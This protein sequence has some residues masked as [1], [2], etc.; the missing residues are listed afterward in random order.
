M[1]PKPERVIVKSENIP[2]ELIDKPRWVC[3]KWVWREGKNG[4]PGKWTKP[5]FDPKTGEKADSTDPSTW[6]PFD[7]A[8]AEY[9]TNGYD[10]IGFV[11][12]KEY[13]GIDFDKLRSPDGTILEPALTEIVKI[14]SYT[15]IS[16]SY[17]GFKTLTK[18][19]L[20]KG[21]H[22][23]K[24]IGVFDNSRYFCITGDVIDG[25]SKNIE[26]R[27]QEVDTLIRR[28]WPQ[29]FE[30]KQKNLI[31]NSDVSDEGLIA[32]IRKSGQRIKFESLWRGDIGKYSSQSEADLALCTILAFWTGKDASRMDRLFRQSGLFRDKWIKHGYNERTIRKAISLT[33]ETYL[34]SPTG[35]RGNTTEDFRMW[36]H[37]CYGTFNIEQIYRDLGITNLKEKNLIR[38]N[39][40]REVERGTIERGQTTGTYRMVDQEADRIEIL[41]KAPVPLSISIP[42]DVNK[43]VNIYPGN[44][45]IIAGSPNAGKTA[46]DLNF[47]YDNRNNFEVI[48]WSSEMESEELTARTLTFKH[49]R[50]EWNKIVFLKRTHDF[51]QVINPNAVNIIDYL[52]V[53]EGEFFKV[54]DNIRKIFEK[55]DR[56]IALVSIQMD[57]GKQLGWGGPKTLDKARLYIT[58][59]K[60]KMT[61][62]KAKNQT[63]SKRN[64]NV[65]G[66]VRRFSFEN[67][68][69]KFVWEEW[70]RAW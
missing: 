44:I 41:E 66:M 25:V 47:A 58:L 43:L 24:Q 42:G 62:V 32:K 5:P 60:G 35:Q 52:E 34:S 27:Q 14:N 50:D 69:S 1:E 57:P 28:F 33:A 31:N 4:K 68:G 67:D 38:V 23:D 29:D 61:I 18:A 45:L 22:H 63:N 9:K 37:E 55:L 3:W 40:S 15:E 8:Y 7:R 10:G 59:D 65:D 70:E 49:P 6:A 20:P 11:L 13:T 2:Q 19:N 36:L 54:G 48:Y 39:L 51:H 17:D 56:G 12:N 26:S 46:F 53:I 64:C 16:P 30:E 21:G